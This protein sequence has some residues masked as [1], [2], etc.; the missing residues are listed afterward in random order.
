MFMILSLAFAA[1]EPAGGA[2]GSPLGFLGSLLPILL[3]FQFFFFF[4]IRPKQ[5]ARKKH[6]AM[7]EGLKKGDRVVSSAGIIGTIVNVDKDTVVLQAAP[8]VKLRILRSSVADLR[9]EE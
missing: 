1:G 6:R 3:I 5:K 7:M 8:E 2:Q 4:V 9:S